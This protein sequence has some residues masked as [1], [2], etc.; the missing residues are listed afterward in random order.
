MMRNRITGVHPR[1]AAQRADGA[2]LGLDAVADHFG[3]T[4]SL[5]PG[6]VVET[7]RTTLAEFRGMA[8][9]TDDLTIL[10]ARLL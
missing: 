7:L 4:F 1:A 5:G 8:P 6:A 10:A 9:P 2:V 3:A